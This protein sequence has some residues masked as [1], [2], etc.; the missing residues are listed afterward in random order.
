MPAAFIGVSKAEKNG[1][2]E[3]AINYRDLESHIR[4]SST[5]RICALSMDKF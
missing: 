4:G 1:R 5:Q 3:P 2:N